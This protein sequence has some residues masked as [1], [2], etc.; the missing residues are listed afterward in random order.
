MKQSFGNLSD[1]RAVSLYTISAGRLK[2]AVTDLGATLV[3]LWVDGVD[4]VLGYDDTSGYLN[5]EGFLGA[6]VGRNANRIQG[7]SFPLNGESVHLIPNEGGNNLHSGPDSWNI[8]L[9]Q[10]SEITDNAIRLCLSS[11]HGDQGFPG[12]ATVSAQAQDALEQA[13]VPED[14]PA[15]LA[16]H[17]PGTHPSGTHTYIGTQPPGTHPPRYT[18]SRYTFTRYTPRQHTHPDNTHTQVH[19]LAI[20]PGNTPRECIHLGNTHVYAYTHEFC[21]TYTKIH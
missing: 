19:T 18:A 12:N 14:I 13:D 5:N 16:A 11:P 10:V 6:V 21:T 7:S 20:H 3:S 9:W 8:R 17:P 4:V 2:A 15:H 1:G